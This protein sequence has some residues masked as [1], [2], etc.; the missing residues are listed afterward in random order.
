MIW[1]E[2]IGALFEADPRIRLE[3]L[4]KPTK[5]LSKHYL[6]SDG[7]LNRDLFNTR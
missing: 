1:E 4:R 2:I 7:D 5:A 3:E 6:F